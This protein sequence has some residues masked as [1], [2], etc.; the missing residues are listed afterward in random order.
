[1]FSPQEMIICDMMEVLAKAMGVV[2]LQYLSVS[3]PQVVCLRLTQ[4]NVSI[5]SQ[6]S[7]GKKKQ[8]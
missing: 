2:V 6:K 4:S 3:N 5:I 8:G 7:W 1:M